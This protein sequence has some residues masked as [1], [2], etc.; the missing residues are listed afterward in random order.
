MSEVLAIELATYEA[1]RARLV[2]EH[3][4]EHVLIKGAE[5]VGTFPT[6]DEARD[7]GWRQF[8]PVPIFV[9]EIR[10]ADPVLTYTGLHVIDPERD[11]LLKERLELRAENERLRAALLLF[12]R[13]LDKP[14]AYR[15]PFIRQ[16]TDTPPPEWSGNAVAYDGAADGARVREVVE[17]LEDTPDAE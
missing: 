9:R 1:N 4:G 10:A 5:I 13:M 8:G 12:R 3:D 11:R 17:E 7:T 6:H 2:A 15:G 16:L 14:S